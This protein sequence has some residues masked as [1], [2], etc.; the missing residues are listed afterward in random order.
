MITA[1]RLCTVSVIRSKLLKP[2]FNT[3]SGVPDSGLDAR[4]YTHAATIT[5]PTDNALDT[6]VFLNQSPRNSL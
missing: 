1:I 4:D 5:L 2:G 3:A 6:A